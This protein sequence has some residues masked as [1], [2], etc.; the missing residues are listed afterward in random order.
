LGFIAHPA[1]AITTLSLV[2]TAL[3]RHS[4]FKVDQR[5]GD[6]MRSDAERQR[7]CVAGAA[8]TLDW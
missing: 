4:T 8:I 3:T 2:R 6:V 7:I 5:F 1:K